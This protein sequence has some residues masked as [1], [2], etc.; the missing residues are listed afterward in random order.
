[1]NEL[2]T[3]YKKKNTRNL[4]RG[5]SDFKKGCQPRASVV[6]WLQSYTGEGTVSVSY[7]AYMGLMMLS[8][9]TYIQLSH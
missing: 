7:G 6:I 8:R 2:E 5:I 4:Y 3:N 9:L 1:M